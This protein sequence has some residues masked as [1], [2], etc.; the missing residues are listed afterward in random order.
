VT[1]NLAFTPD[2]QLVL[3]PT[4]NPT[5]DSLWILGLRGRVTF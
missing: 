5:K 2:I 4:L 3:N 1:E